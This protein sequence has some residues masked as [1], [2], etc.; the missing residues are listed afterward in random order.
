MINFNTSDGVR[1]SDNMGDFEAPVYKIKP[2]IYTQNTIGVVGLNATGKTTILEIML[3]ILHIVFNHQ[4]LNYDEAAR[5]LHK[6]FPEQS[7]DLKWEVIRNCWI[8]SCVKIIFMLTFAIQIKD[9]RL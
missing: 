9:Y 5:I 7:M 3:L 8:A 6:I 4:L 2:G 1:A